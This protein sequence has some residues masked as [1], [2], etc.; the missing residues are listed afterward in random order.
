[1]SCNYAVVFR[2]YNEGIAYRIET[3]LAQREV[4]IYNEEV[5]LNFAGDYHVYYPKEESFFSHNERDFLY[6]ALK[7][8]APD[9][10]ASLPALVEAA[11]GVKIAVAESDVDDFPGLWLRGN[12]SNGLSGIFPPY[13]QKEQLTRDRDLKVTETANHIALTNGARTYP[14]RIL[15]IAARDADLITNELVYLLAKPS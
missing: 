7:E 14:W 2:A 15:G 3:N 1:M 12:N 5:K 4:K 6:L 8:I 10:I 9:S 13:P 11:N